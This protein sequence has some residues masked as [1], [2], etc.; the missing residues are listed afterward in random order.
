MQSTYAVSLL[1]LTAWGVFT[2]VAN[3]CA[4]RPWST[5]R[6]NVLGTQV[7]FIIGCGASASAMLCNAFRPWLL[8]PIGLSLWW[9]VPYPCYFAVVNDVR[10]IHAAR[11]V[12]FI[13][14]G[15]ALLLV[16]LGLV[17]LSQFGV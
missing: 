6:W 8:A 9:M 14:I 10:W 16:A 13:A 11:N 2:L 3:V 15:L 17:P 7:V 1:V 4:K 5:R 12:V